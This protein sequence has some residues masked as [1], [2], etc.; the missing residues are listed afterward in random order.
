MIE[1]NG[2]KYALKYLF[3]A[4]YK[5]G[6]SYL[7]GAD[8]ISLQDPSK[9]A[10]YDVFY[11]PIKPLGELE[12]FSLIGDD[13]T[14]SVSLTDGHFEIDGNISTNFLRSILASF[15]FCFSSYFILNKLPD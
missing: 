15:I 6:E 2:Q 1:V 7:Q 13:H 8:D 3:E 11:S 12:S 10:F 9:N 5:D 4:Q 14:Y